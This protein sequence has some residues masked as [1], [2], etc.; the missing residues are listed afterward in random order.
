MQVSVSVWSTATHCNIFCYSADVAHRHRPSSGRRRSKEGEQVTSARCLVIPGARVI[1][2]LANRTLGQSPIGPRLLKAL[3]SGIL[4]YQA[5]LATGKG[6]VR[7]TSRTPTSHQSREIK[8]KALLAE[9]ASD[10]RRRTTPR[11]LLSRQGHPCRSCAA[12]D[13]WR[14]GGR[15]LEALY[16]I[17]PSVGFGLRVIVMAFDRRLALACEL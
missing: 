2:S 16:P 9:V 8:S 6:A 4:G 17:R 7:L 15:L 5:Q 3:L 10:R 1:S 13:L 11:W 12:E 14:Q